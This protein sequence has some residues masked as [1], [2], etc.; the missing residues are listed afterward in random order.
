MRDKAILSH[1]E[2]QRQIAGCNEP[3]C[4]DHT[5]VKMR[6][7]GPVYLDADDIAALESVHDE[8]AYADFHG[9]RHPTQTRD[10][11]LVEALIA[12]AKGS[13]L[14]VHEDDGLT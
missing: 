10:Y 11:D 7:F 8:V 3:N 1:F 6:V 5:V 14:P 2:P 12:R 4:P 13:A 9:A